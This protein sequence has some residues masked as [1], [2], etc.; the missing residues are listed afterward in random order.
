M[1][2]GFPMIATID[3]ATAAERTRIVELM[4]SYEQQLQAQAEALQE[5]R[6]AAATGLGAQLELLRLLI[7]VVQK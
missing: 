7:S 5:H 6:L 1:T 2:L 4:L 3:A